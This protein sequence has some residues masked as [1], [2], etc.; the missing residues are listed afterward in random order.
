MHVAHEI[1]KLAQLLENADCPPSRK[2]ATMFCSMCRCRVVS[3]FGGQLYQNPM[4]DNCTDKCLNLV[5]FYPI[6]AHVRDMH[7]ECAVF[8]G[9]VNVS[10]GDK[11]TTLCVGISNTCRI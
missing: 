11:S 10:I 7:N 4:L 2:H 3:A 9:S 5:I 6:T 8:I 1:E